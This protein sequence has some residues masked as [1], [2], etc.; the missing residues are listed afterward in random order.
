VTNLER[1][2]LIFEIIPRFGVNNSWERLELDWMLRMEY[3]SL[4]ATPLKA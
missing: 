1:L 3:P 4:I 2:E